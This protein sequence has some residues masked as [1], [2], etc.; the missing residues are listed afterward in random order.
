MHLAVGSWVGSPDERVCTHRGRTCVEGMRLVHW[1][2]V[3]RPARASAERVLPRGRRECAGGRALAHARRCHEPHGANHRE[4]GVRA[5]WC[6]CVVCVSVYLCLCV[7]CECVRALAR[8]RHCCS[9]WF[10]RYTTECDGCR[11]VATGPRDADVRRDPVAAA[12][13]LRSERHDRGDRGGAD[14][15][16]RVRDDHVPGDEPALLTAARVSACGVS[17]CVS[18]SMV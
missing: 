11:A 18:V 2:Q 6:V 1:P 10:W 15:G 3:R 5:R 14:S 7:V 17:V 4:P 12:G 9:A 16:A 8:A 13:P